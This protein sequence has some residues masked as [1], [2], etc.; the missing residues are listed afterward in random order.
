M[1]RTKAQLAERAEY[2]DYLREWFGEVSTDETESRA[3]LTVWTILRHRSNDT[4]WIDLIVVRDGRAHSIG[5]RSAKALDL[6]W[7]DTHYGIRVNG[8]GMDMG[9]DLVHTLSRA[10]FGPG[11]PDGSDP[12]YR[13]NH[14]WL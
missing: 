9:Y 7:S 14:D 11:W 12:G 8:G 13:L 10:L 1:T 5:Y 4:R 3:Y 6:P 2:L